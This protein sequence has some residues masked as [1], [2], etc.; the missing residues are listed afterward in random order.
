LLVPAWFS[1][2]PGAVPAWPPLG[3]PDRWVQV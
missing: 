3:P 2:G 1:P